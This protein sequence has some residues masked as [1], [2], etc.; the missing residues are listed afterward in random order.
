[1]PYE[2]AR[3]W[4]PPVMY[5]PMCNDCV[6]LIRG[7]ITCKAFPE[8]IPKDITSGRHDHHEPYPGDSGIRFEARKED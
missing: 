5:R 2:D 6:H 4:T 3:W 7:T 1:M 8:R